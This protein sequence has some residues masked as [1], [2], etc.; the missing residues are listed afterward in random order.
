[1]NNKNR[2][3]FQKQTTFDLIGR[4]HHP[5]Y[6]T[7][8]TTFTS[9]TTILSADVNTNFSTIYTDYTAKFNPTTG[10]G[11][12]GTGTDGPGLSA[13][14]ITAGTLAV[15]RGGTGLAS[16]AV[17]DIPYASGATTIAK[18]A[19]VAA[20]AYVRSAG[21]TTA[22]VWSTL[23]LPNAA[24]ISTLLYASAADVISALATA[25]SGV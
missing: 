6:L 23:T 15:A 22:P 1:M 24:A 10:H 8:P 5:R 25:N 14:V 21:V 11:H 18:L 4:E 13:A 19:A 12:T 7:V 9:G 16:Y 20:G 3:R 2:N 17:G